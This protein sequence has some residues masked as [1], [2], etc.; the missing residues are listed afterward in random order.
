MLTNFLFILIA[1]LSA[2]LMVS[3]SINKMNK[4]TVDNAKNDPIFRKLAEEGC[5]NSITYLIIIILI[6]TI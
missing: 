2:L 3:S 6:I 4:I 5:T 1:V